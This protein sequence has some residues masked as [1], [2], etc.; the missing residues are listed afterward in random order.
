[1]SEARCRGSPPLTSFTLSDQTPFDCKL[2]NR[3]PTEATT[4]AAET[5]VLKDELNES[6]RG[7]VSLDSFFQLI[8]PSS[9]SENAAEAARLAK[10]RSL[11]SLLTQYTKATKRG[12]L[13]T[14][15][16][17]PL[18]KMINYILKQRHSHF[19]FVLTWRRALLGSKCGRLYVY[20]SPWDGMILTSILY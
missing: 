15:L 6:L 13:E 16:Y 18:Q 5:P 12:G 19:E 17:H 1:M 4:R 2:E 8:F 14:R 7:A 20:P 9:A 3:L 11:T 10:H